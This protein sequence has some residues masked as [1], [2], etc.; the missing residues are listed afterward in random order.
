[1]ELKIDCDCGQRYKFDVEPVGGRMPVTVNCPSCQTDGTSTANARLA[2][3]FQLAPPPKPVAPAL[4]A[5]IGSTVTTMAAMPSP[6]PVP[7]PPSAPPPPPPTPMGGLR[8]NHAPPPPPTA[9][10]APPPATIAALRPLSTDKKAKVQ[11][12]EFSMVRGIIGGVIGSVVGCGL[13]YAFWLW[14]HFRF[15]LS[16][17]AVGAA[18]GYGARWLAR[19][20]H[21]TMGIIVAAVAGLTVTGTFVLMYGGFAI[22]TIISIVI[23]VSVAYRAASE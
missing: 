8:I 1:M 2:E 11:T 9:S 12:G 4:F 7:V 20:T 10:S 13:L 18:A 21:T 15:P 19:G 14:A 23:C 16:S 5:P 22:F 17:I 6:A 3:H